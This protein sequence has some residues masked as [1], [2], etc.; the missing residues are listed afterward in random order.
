[1]ARGTDPTSA[2]SV[3]RMVGWERADGGW[4]L[5]WQGWSARTYEIERSA[6]LAIPG[7][8]VEIARNRPGEDGLTSFTHTTAT[9]TWSYFYRVRVEE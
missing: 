8:F 3:L 9:G 6:D 1:M 7:S 5:T 4:R 2:L